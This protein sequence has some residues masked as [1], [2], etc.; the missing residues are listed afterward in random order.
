MPFE[1][2]YHICCA[3]K[4]AMQTGKADRCHLIPYKIQCR[5]CYA[6]RNAVK[7]HIQLHAIS[8]AVQAWQCRGTAAQCHI[9]CA[10]LHGMQCSRHINRMQCR[11]CRTPRMQ[12]SASTVNAMPSEMQSSP[13]GYVLCHIE[14][15]PANATPLKGGPMLP[16]MCSAI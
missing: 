9:I 14:S 2:D 7:R 5:K 1:M 16:D 4:N 12:Y 8:D 10:E 6:M 11:K 3:I 15:S 13:A